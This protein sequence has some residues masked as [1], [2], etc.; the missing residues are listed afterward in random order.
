MRGGIP[1][2]PHQPATPDQ[3]V[4]AEIRPSPTGKG[5]LYVQ[6]ASLLRRNIRERTWQSGQKL[7]S[8]E[9]LADE[10]AV[11]LATVRQAVLLL[12]EEGLLRRIHGKG[13]YVTYTA[14]VRDWLRVAT[15]WE[16]ILSFY[17]DANNRISVKNIEKAQIGSLPPHVLAYVECVPASSYKYM[18]RI[19]SI[20]DL[21]YASSNVYL[22]YDLFTRFPNEFESILALRV[23][24]SIRPPVVREAHQFLVIANADAK[25]S[26]DLNIS[27]GSA[28]AEIR[29]SICDYSNKLIYYS[30]MYYR[31]DLVQLESRLK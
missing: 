10:F 27:P 1:R 16:G 5:K 11:S 19:L 26:S 21:P 24:D 29:R 15:T 14:G 13:T 28:I 30:I 7:P 9:A 8:L 2:G 22:D 4:R 25:T 6:L 18:R 31:G 23:I 17:E 3:G 20:D 12:E